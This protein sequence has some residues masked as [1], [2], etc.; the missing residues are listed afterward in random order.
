M[1]NYPNYF[2]FPFVRQFQHWKSKTIT[3]L[4]FMTVCHFYSGIFFPLKAQNSTQNP[5]Q[6]SP[7]DSTSFNHSERESITWNNPRLP[8]VESL[9]LQ[10]IPLLLPLENELLNISTKDI[11]LNKILFVELVEEM[12]PP[13]LRNYAKLNVGNYAAW[14]LESL[15][16]LTPQEDWTIEPFINLRGTLWGEKDRR[17]SSFSQADV[18]LKQKISLNEKTKTT[19]WVQFRRQ[20]FGLYGYQISPEQTPPDWKRIRQTAYSFSVIQDLYKRHIGNSNSFLRLKGNYFFDN[21]KKEKRSKELTANL[22]F[23]NTFY[24]DNKMRPLAE[25]LLYEEEHT[26]VK[27]LPLYF[28]SEIDW[29]NDISHYSPQN[30]PTDSLTFEQ[31]RFFS[32]L[33]LEWG[34][35]NKKWTLSAGL[36]TL[37]S[38]AAFLQQT[39]LQTKRQWHFFPKLSAS[40]LLAP[41][42]TNFYLNSFSA[43]QPI[44]LEE[45]SIENPYYAFALVLPNL[46]RW[47]NEIGAKI[48][49]SKNF[50]YKMSA[51]KPMPS[52]ATLAQVE[53]IYERV[54]NLP[55]WIHSPQD[56]TTFSLI[57][58]RA[59]V[60][61]LHFEA[62]VRFSHLPLRF[63]ASTDLMKYQLQNQQQ[64]WYLPTW[65]GNV[66]VEY[67]FL[68]K[69]EAELTWLWQTG[70]SYQRATEVGK[71]PDIHELNLAFG[72]LMSK[73]W[74][75]S[76]GCRNV[77]GLQREDFWGYD[78]LRWQAFA[79]AKYAF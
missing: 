28:F 14:Q 61:Q 53:F 21:P 73:N 67:L 60:F 4:V 43:S 7:Q 58:D 6:D 78:R 11:Q 40:Y 32:Q 17:N 13:N 15:L 79:G 62:Q 31:T 19:N 51:F 36:Q 5:P 35:K 27:T 1:Q 77:L 65:I 54:E 8:K 41:L 49:F 72:Y 2:T 23:N 57:T 42:H 52:V 24:F 18:S 29:K 39:A 44:H 59:Q 25:R 68:K 34:V 56:S 22:H 45:L 74:T 55:L 48:D 30:L 75:V 66:G 33:G 38:R 10:S 9:R 12:P 47:R 26:K 71:L 46:I 69:I 76:A 20:A 70:R 3:T 37:Y 63:F 64:A 16:E 50:N